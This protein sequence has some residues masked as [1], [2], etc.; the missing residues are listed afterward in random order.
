[1]DH[2]Q[3]N[4]RS[5]DMHVFLMQRLCKEPHK[6]SGLKDVWA[7][8]LTLPSFSCKKIYA[9]AWISAIEAG[10]TA[11]VT[12]ATSKS[13]FHNTLRQCSPCG[14]LWNNDQERLDFMRQWKAINIDSSR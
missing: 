5:L 9:D 2:L 7:N 14:I 8:W 10:V 6:L 13:D 1:M 3:I 4:Q 12:L 11:V